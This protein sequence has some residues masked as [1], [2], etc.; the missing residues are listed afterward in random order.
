M[1]TLA[2][3]RRPQTEK[4]GIISQFI[5]LYPSFCY[6]LHCSVLL[7]RKLG[8]REYL[9]IFSDILLS[10]KLGYK[11]YFKIFSDILLPRKLGYN[12][13]LRIFSDI[14][15]TRACE[16]GG[17]KTSPPPPLTIFL[18]FSSY[19]LPFLILVCPA[20]HVRPLRGLSTLLALTPGRSRSCGLLRCA[21]TPVRRPGVI[22]GVTPSGSVSARSYPLMLS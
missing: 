6:S 18:F 7:P 19:K 13:Y 10:R 3:A 9:R 4:I 5:L 8:Y 17:K 2:A 12:E 16:V 11:K 14:L 21:T 22:D 15:Y 1:K 20:V